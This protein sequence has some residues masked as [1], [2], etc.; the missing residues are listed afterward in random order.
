MISHNSQDMEAP[1]S[2]SVDQQIKVKQGTYT[3]KYFSALRKKKIHIC[4]NMDEYGG[5]ILSEINQI[6]S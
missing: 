6:R 3:M 1:K 2:L 5:H 4:D